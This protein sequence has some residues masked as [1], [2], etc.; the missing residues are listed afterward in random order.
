[1]IKI[2]IKIV[3]EDQEAAAE[4]AEVAEEKEEADIK[5]GLFKRKSIAR[6]Q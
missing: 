2:F 6:T 5:K 1:L 3:E 4:V